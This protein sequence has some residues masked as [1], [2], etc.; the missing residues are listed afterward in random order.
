MPS[1]GFMIL[2]RIYSK[3]PSFFQFRFLET[4]KCVHVSSIYK[5][6]NTTI[7]LFLVKLTHFTLLEQF[8]ARLLFKKKALATRKVPVK[9]D[10]IRFILQTVARFLGFLCFSRRASCGCDIPGWPAL[11]R[12]VETTQN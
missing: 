10:P 11:V 4:R 3:F 6:D 2:G 12:R 1:A 7:K 5:D 9:T 8:A